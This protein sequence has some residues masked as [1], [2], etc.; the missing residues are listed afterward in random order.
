MVK[1]KTRTF[2]GKKKPV[3]RSAGRMNTHKSNG[4]LPES[5]AV[6]P[7][8]EPERVPVG[9][10]MRMAVEAL[11][12]VTVDGEL[13]AQQMRDLAADYDEVERRKA[14]FN[15]KAEEAKTAKKAL[16][17]ATE[18]LLE[19]LRTYTHATPMPLFDETQAEADHE[20]ML[21][22]AEAEQGIPLTDLEPSEVDGVPADV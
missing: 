12:P 2:R 15:A 6:A 19:K 20:A 3:A 9:E 5:Q 8:A 7:T 11:G 21:D 17:A 4:S 1:K 16:D 10:A 22:A 13:A 18:L 14:A